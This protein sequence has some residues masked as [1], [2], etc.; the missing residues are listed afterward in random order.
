MTPVTWCLAAA[1]ILTLLAWRR[2][3]RIASSRLAQA[4]EHLAIADAVRA[5][6][7][8]LEAALGGAGDGLIVLD[9]DGRIVA[10]NAA[11]RELANLPARELR[12]QRLE[13]LVPW[14]VLHRA[15]QTC[16]SG[17]EAPAFEL[18][19]AAGHGRTLALRVQAL[20]GLGTVIGIDDQS[21]LK[22]LESLRR[23]FVA[24]VSHELKTPLAAIQGLVE[25]M[26]DDPDME[27]ATRLRFLER[28]SRQSERLRAL[29]GDLLT[30]SHLDEDPGHD[31]AATP[32]DLGA[33]LR[34]TM[35][36]L[37]P[38]ADKQGL[39][40]TVVLPWHGCWVRAEREA[41]R[42]VAGNLIDNAIKYTPSGGQLSVRLTPRERRVRLE[43]TDTGIGL[44]PADQER[45]FERFYRV[46]RARSR[47]LGGT[48]LGLSIVKNTVRNLGGE[49][50]VRSALG[51]GSTFWVELPLALED[52]A[53]SEP[54]AS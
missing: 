6:A 17:G 11:A 26:L 44:S 10:A 47:D 14:P 51:K 7:Q 38:I 2:S 4:H 8:R 23:D 12:G 54:A 22:R 13:D 28:I 49:V 16:R 43:V 19:E 21:R 15:V 25:T 27:V 35:R 41:L 18:D 29:V 33:V 53:D 31:E 37:Q 45:V 3:R 40:T 24:N 39:Q 46:D 36:D 1:L 48:G 9:Q 5:E 30:L 52:D 20:P 34:E 32:C 50:G 42:R